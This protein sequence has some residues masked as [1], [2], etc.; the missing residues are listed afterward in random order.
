MTKGA[1]SAPREGRKRASPIAG[2]LT[3]ALLANVAIQPARAHSDEPLLS[4]VKNT[5]YGAMTGLV[6]GGV[7]TLVVDDED[8]DDVVRWGVVIGTFGGFGF[9]IYEATRN[10]D[11]LSGPSRGED[12]PAEI[13]RADW[14][15]PLV[16]RLDPSLNRLVPSSPVPAPALHR[17]ISRILSGS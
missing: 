8:R 15:A 9:G 17:E 2:V 14:E 4:V 7:L 10:D 1:S 16:S 6:L 12:G 11:L 13:V 5:L 3:L